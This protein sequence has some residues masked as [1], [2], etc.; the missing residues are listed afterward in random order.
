M[1]LEDFHSLWSAKE[2][3]KQIKEHAEERARAKRY[4]QELDDQD[5]KA[6]A[7]K[8]L[9]EMPEVLVLADK[10]YFIV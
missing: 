3:Q 4:L 8:F 6:E 7:K 9:F 2:A 5:A 1:T 10:D